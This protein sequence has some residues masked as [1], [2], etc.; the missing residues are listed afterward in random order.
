MQLDRVYLLDYN[1]GLRPWGFTLGYKYAAPMEL[2]KFY[3]KQIKQKNTMTV[4]GSFAPGKSSYH[5]SNSR[6]HAICRTE[7]ISA[8]D[9][10]IGG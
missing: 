6:S 8:K 1:P 2:K 5:K 10:R 3:I 4:H 9:G 7:I